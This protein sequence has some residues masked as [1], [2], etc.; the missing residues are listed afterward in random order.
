MEDSSLYYNYEQILLDEKRVFAKYFFS[1][2]DAVCEKNALRVMKFAFENYLRWTP[3]E[4]ADNLNEEI[5]KKLKLLYLVKYVRFPAELDPKEDYFYI[6]HKLYPEKIKY[7]VVESTRRVFNRVVDGN[8]K[9]FPKGFFSD[10]DGDERACLCFQRMLAQ[11]ELTFHSIKETYQFFSTSKGNSM[12][13]KYRLYS[14][15]HHFF[16]TALDFLHESLSDEERSPLWLHYYSFFN[17]Y[18]QLEADKQKN[19]Q[20]NTLEENS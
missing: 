5:L 20:Q 17:E 4:L 7:D 9:K 8:R 18:D 16:G 11:S 13:I 12:L 15:M 3:E 14:Q 2:I 6:A 10:S 19:M 1:G